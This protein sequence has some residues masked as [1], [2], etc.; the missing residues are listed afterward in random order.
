VAT[1]CAVG[2]LVLPALSGGQTGEPA[3]T[4]PNVAGT[5]TIDGEVYPFEPKTCLLTDDTFVAA[6]PGTRDDEPFVASVSSKAGL[7]VAFGVRTEVDQPEP[8]HLWWTSGPLRQSRVE[9]TSLRATAKV[10]DRSGTV[11]G[12]RIAVINVTCPPSS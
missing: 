5:V 11:T 7:E 12:P 2:L 10:E 4:A 8:D 3:P 9:G 1:A 6:G